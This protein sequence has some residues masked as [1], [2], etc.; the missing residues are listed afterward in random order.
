MRIACKLKPTAIL[1][2]PVC[3]EKFPRIFVLVL[4]IL[5]DKYEIRK[6]DYNWMF[7]LKEM[8]L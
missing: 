1:F 6:S 8:A 7:V 2:K 4:S 5:N 3:S